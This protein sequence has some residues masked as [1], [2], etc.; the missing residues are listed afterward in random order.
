M[1][2]EEGFGSSF[3]RLS[4]RPGQE[5]AP[6]ALAH[7]HIRLEQADPEGVAD[8]AVNVPVA[9]ENRLFLGQ[10]GD[11]TV[12]RCRPGGLAGCMSMELEMTDSFTRAGC[13]RWLTFVLEWW[14][15][16]PCVQAG[17]TC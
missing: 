8:V 12:A 4:G 5:A 14:L 7:Q 6:L 11:A 13:A 2:R 17:T 15:S 9:V 16:L 1:A 3:G 10:E